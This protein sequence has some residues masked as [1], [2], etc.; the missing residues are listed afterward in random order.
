MKNG[1]LRKLAAVLLAVVMVIG[2][3]A[4]GGGSDSNEV[5]LTYW[6]MWE[7]SETQG[8]ALQEAVDAFTAE[9]GIKVDLQ[10]KGRQG[11]REGLQPALDAK[12]E[13]DIFDEDVD[14]VNG[15]WGN[16]IIDLED[17]FKN[18]SLAKQSRPAF[19]QWCRDAGG[20]TLKTIPYQE[21]VFA[22]HYNKDIFDKA[23]VTK[24]PETWDEFV[25]VCEQIRAA[26]YDPICD[27]VDYIDCMYGY[28]LARLIGQDAAEEM[29][30]NGTWKEV[31]E[32]LEAAKLFEDLAKR[33]LFSSTIASSPWPNAQNVELGG[34]TAAMEFCGS[35]L[36]NEIRGVTGDDFEWGGFAFPD[37]PGQKEGREANNTS[38][39]VFAINKESKHPDEA[40][41]LIEW[42][43]TGKWDQNLTEKSWG[44]PSDPTNTNVPDPQVDFAKICDATTV[45]YQWAAAAE[46]NGDIVGPLMENFCRLCGGQI[47]SEEFIDAMAA[48]Y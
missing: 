1:M 35:W 12:T 47:T 16:Y 4:C 22:F 13:I 39:Q 14:R 40:F 42:L 7:A 28:A 31:P 23:G 26:G 24:A 9:T 30:M 25:A 48:A 37:I 8:M 33:G 27:D 34:G 17:Y 32:A 6:C 38:F 3:T 11:I 10:F 46:N 18:S 44:I 36:P 5:T 45:R 43:S 15:N 19:V 21:S 20:G 29:Y 2:L 41:K